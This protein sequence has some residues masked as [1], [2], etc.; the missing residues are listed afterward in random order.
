MK[1]QSIPIQD[2]LPSKT[3]HRILLAIGIVAAGSLLLV[4]AAFAARHFACS[5][6]SNA[7]SS[8]LSSPG[9]PSPSD[10]TRPPSPPEVSS[11]SDAT[12]PSRPPEASSPS[13]ATSPSSPSDAGS[14][15]SPQPS[16]VREDDGPFA[17]VESEAEALEYLSTELK[18][19]EAAIEF[20]KTFDG[21][22]VR[23][24]LGDKTLTC[25]ELVKAFVFAK[26]VNGFEAEKESL[27]AQVL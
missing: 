5:Q 27:V 9:A 17:G 8:P 2:L 21:C 3:S 14:V 18:E 6:P 25:D 10:A 4:G 1:I 23:F 13:D 22:F 11:P 16:P 15:S 20:A 24:Y 19:N 26:D 7:S 12:S